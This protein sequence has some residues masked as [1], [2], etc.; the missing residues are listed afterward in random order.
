MISLDSYHMKVRGC[1]LLM[2]G[3]GGGGDLQGGHH[4]YD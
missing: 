1:S 3:E 2:M 4:V